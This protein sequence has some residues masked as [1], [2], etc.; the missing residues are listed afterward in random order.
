MSKRPAGPT[1]GTSWIKLY[2][3]CLLEAGPGPG[4]FKAKAKGVYVETML[5]VTKIMDLSPR[6][7]IEHL[8]FRRPMYQRTPDFTETE[9]F[10]SAYFL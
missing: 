1:C 5:S 2:P 6:G 4:M 10:L 9:S 8:K 3:E 7:I